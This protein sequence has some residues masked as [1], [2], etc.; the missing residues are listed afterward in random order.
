VRNLPIPRGSQAAGQ[1]ISSAEDMAH[2]LLAHLNAG[3]YGDA[4]I[5]SGEGIDELHRGGVEAREM[6]VSVG[7]YGMGW[8]I[9][10]IGQ[11]KTIW[12][13]GNV[14]DFSSYMALLPEQKKGLVLLVNADHYGLPPVLPEVGL[15]VTALLAGQPPAAIQLGFIPWVMRALPLIPL[16][17]IAGVAATL[18]RLRRWRRDPALRPSRGHMWG[19]HILLPLIP[20]LSLAAIPLFLRVRGML[21]FLSLFTPDFF[22]IALICGGFGGVWTFLRTAL[23]LQTL[24]KPGVS[25]TLME[26]T[27]HE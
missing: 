24:R 21:R 18:R 3:R 19:L 1:L 20:N 5:L 26:D 12:H 11:T 17:Q 15:R 23:I 2:Y 9:T 22:W 7:Q 4:Q 8:F 27:F 14:P 16:L 6:G 10:D 25:Q 13:S